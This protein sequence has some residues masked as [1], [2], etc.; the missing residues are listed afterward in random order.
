MTQGVQMSQGV[1]VVVN[2]PQ[3]LTV[4]NTVTHEVYTFRLTTSLLSSF[5]LIVVAVVV[6]VFLG[7]E[8]VAEVIFVVFFVVVLLVFLLVEVVVLPASTTSI[9]IA[10]NTNTNTANEKL[11]LILLT[12]AVKFR[13]QKRVNRV[14]RTTTTATNECRK[15]RI[16]GRPPS[17]PTS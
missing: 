3:S 4:S 7:F 11:H 14:G 15:V 5:L 12:A 1:T 16:D 2:G 13:N 8:V 10:N 6:F 9:A 17:T